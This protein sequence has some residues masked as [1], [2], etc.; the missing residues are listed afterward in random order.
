M[1]PRLKRDAKQAYTSAIA[2]SHAR[3]RAHIKEERFGNK[4]FEVGEK[5][6]ESI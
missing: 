6:G 4:L 5:D 2:C 1:V 3:A